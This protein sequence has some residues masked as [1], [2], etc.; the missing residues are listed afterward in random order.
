MELLYGFFFFT[1]SMDQRK[2]ERKTKYRDCTNLIEIFVVFGTERKP[3]SIIT[4]H[5]SRRLN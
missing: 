5:F 1:V 4:C 2:G 3:L